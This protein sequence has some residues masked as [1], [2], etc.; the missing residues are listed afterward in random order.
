MAARKRQTPPIYQPT[1]AEIR[2]ACE[3]IQEGWSERECRRRAGLN[4]ESGWLPPT[5]RSGDVSDEMNGFDWA[6]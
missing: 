1:P 5:I 6:A 4:P 2:R 3:E